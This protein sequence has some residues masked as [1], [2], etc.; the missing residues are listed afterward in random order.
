MEAQCRLFAF[1]IF[2]IEPLP[3]SLPLF[4]TYTDH[5]TEPRLK[6]L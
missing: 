6:L 4:Y 5:K 1:T 2:I 3:L